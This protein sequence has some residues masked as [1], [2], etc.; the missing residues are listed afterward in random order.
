MKVEAAPQVI[1]NSIKRLKTVDDSCA[2]SAAEAMRRAF[3][4]RAWSHRSRIRWAV[5]AMTAWG[6]RSLFDALNGSK[7]VVAA[8]HR[9]DLPGDM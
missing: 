7:H 3:T 5:S 1:D 8:R 2:F 4:Q 9:L 6:W